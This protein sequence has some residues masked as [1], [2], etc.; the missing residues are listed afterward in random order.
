M[1]GVYGGYNIGCHMSFAQATD[2]ALAC[3]MNIPYNIPHIQTEIS[4]GHIGPPQL[5]GHELRTALII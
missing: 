1:M 4:E 3:T 2:V 5:C